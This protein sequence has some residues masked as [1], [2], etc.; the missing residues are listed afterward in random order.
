MQ[1]VTGQ[2]ILIS[3]QQPIT[4]AAAAAAARPT[5]AH[6]QTLLPSIIGATHTLPKCSN[7][8]KPGNH[9]EGLLGI[10]QSSACLD[11]ADGEIKAYP[12]KSLADGS[13]A[14]KETVAVTMV[15]QTAL[16]TTPWAESRVYKK[17]QN[18]LFI[19]Y[20]REGDDIVYHGAALFTAANPLM[21]QLEE[22][23]AL[24]QAKAA[25][26][27]MT[28]T[29]GTYLQTRTKGAGHGS[30]SRA[31]YLRTSFLAALRAQADVGPAP[32]SEKGA[33][34]LRKL[35]EKRAYAQMDLEE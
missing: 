17:L 15:D 4:M 29:I 12:L 10:P 8:G 24:I 16:L 34:L 26:G 33:A 11:C 28:G 13:L 7:K 14:V 23:Y 32:I 35:Q 3:S 19:P 9:L 2:P 22:D 20:M 25:E 30:T 18:T 6:V 21:R 27:I 5:I 1:A 31:F